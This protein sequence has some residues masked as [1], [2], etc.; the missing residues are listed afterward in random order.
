MRN[1]D[2]RFADEHDAHC[3]YRFLLALLVASLKKYEMIIRPICATK[4]KAHC[5]NH[6]MKHESP[7]QYW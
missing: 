5:I 4:P 6:F 3:P 1:V 7:L 2:V